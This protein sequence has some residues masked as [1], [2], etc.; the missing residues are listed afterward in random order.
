MTEKEKIFSKLY[1]S[2]VVFTMWSAL[3]SIANL[4]SSKVEL[5]KYWDNDKYDYYSSYP[6]SSIGAGLWSLPFSIPICV[7]L[8][9]QKSKPSRCYEISLLI[10]SIFLFG[11]LIGELLTNSV[12]VSNAFGDRS[13]FGIACYYLNIL[14]TCGQMI[15][16]LFLFGYG[17]KY[18]CM[19][20]CDADTEMQTR[21]GSFK[22]S[23]HLSAVKVITDEGQKL[24]DINENKISVTVNS[25]R[26]ILIVDIS[27]SDYQSTDQ[28]PK[29][30]Q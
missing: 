25:G 7:I 17:C 20:C 29:Y 15:T 26:K 14:G 18:V 30:E 2:F 22:L 23:S 3:W 21:S 9:F 19:P 28:P 1:A 11:V 12:M 24:I 4:I 27:N 13:D 5:D 10:L 6:E 8:F 16:D